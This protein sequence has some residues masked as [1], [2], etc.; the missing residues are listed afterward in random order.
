MGEWC[1]FSI[2][3]LLA[4]LGV[5]A[6]FYPLR[7]YKVLICFFV[8]VVLVLLMVAYFMWGDYF[9]LQ[10]HQLKHKKA[11][12]VQMMLQSP[13]RTSALIQTMTRRLDKTPKSAEGWYLVGKLY[14]SQKK[15]HEARDA[16]ALAYQL[17]SSHIQI[18]LYYA[19]C[20]WELNHQR[21]NIKSRRILH[22]V[23]KLNPNQPDALAMLAMDAYSMHHYDQAIT[24]WERLLVL[25]PEGSE[26]AKAIQRAIVRAGKKK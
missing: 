4:A 9:G 20:L 25:V 11:Q 23:L 2:L 8:P 6:A 19:E 16:F 10:A 13:E 3:I 15:Y 14:L 12:E 7:K 18:G 24:Y 26:E 17:N 5:L 1:L 21:F 22:H